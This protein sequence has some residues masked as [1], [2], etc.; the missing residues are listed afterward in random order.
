MNPMNLVAGQDL[1]DV[2]FP[3]ITARTKDQIRV[4]RPWGNLL[5]VK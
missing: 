1:K 5:V 4:L 3:L 2:N